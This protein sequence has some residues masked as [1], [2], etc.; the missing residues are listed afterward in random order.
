MRPLPQTAWLANAAV[1]ANPMSREPLHPRSRLPRPQPNHKPRYLLQLV[2]DA[3]SMYHLRNQ[4]TPDVN[5]V[6]ARPR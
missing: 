5:V 6:V 1:N 4:S 3:E 2:L